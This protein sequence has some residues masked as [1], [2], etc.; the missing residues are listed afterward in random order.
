MHHRQRQRGVGA[1]ANLQ[2]PVRGLGRPRPDRIDD[3]ELRAAAP[4]FAHERPV[5]EVGDDRV[6]PPQHDE[7]AVD[8]LF[9]ID[10][11]ADA[12]RR[13][14]PGGGHRAADVAV[15]RAAA[16]RSH[17]PPIQRVHLDEPLHAGGAVRKDRFR[18]GLGGDRLPARCDV[19]ERVVPGDALESC[20]ALRSHPAQRVQ[21]P[22]RVIDTLEVVVHLRAEGAARERMSG[23]ADERPGAAVPDL[24]DPATGV[25][26]IM[27]ARAA[28]VLSARSG[29]R[30]LSS[31][32]E[33]G[34][35]FRAAQGRS[36]SQT[37]QPHPPSR[38]A[39]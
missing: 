24:D 27:P 14:Q 15:E 11:A 23:I 38:R 7:A 12:N 30:H 16:H 35:G 34:S 3:D 39:S 28:H 4:R 21:H 13:D 25:R 8:D 17:E 2:V 32:V 19:G 5:V 22:I 1:G 26:T 37:G 20:V 6:G 18:A 10:A 31:I 36:R 9:G 33:T 29:V